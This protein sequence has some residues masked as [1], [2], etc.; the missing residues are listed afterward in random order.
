MRRAAYCARTA[1]TS[2]AW[3]ASR[4]SS[5]AA[6]PSKANSRWRAPLLAVNPTFE[7][8]D[9]VVREACGKQFTAAVA[10]IEHRGQP[11][12]EAAYGVTREDDLQR[13]VY[14]DTAF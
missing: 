8:V 5:S 2:R 14:V 13:T 6:S 12:F 9:R 3:K 1:T 7:R 4:T 11:V 10:R